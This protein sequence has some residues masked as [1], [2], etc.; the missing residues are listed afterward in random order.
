MFSYEG[1]NLKE[2]DY[3]VLESFLERKS[4]LFPLD[5]NDPNLLSL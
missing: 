4:P 1:I 5:D 3:K 2:R